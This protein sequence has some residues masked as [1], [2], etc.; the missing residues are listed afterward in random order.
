M[1]VLSKV[2]D[3]VHSFS[4]VGRSNCNNRSISTMNEGAQFRHTVSIQG[5]PVILQ[6]DS[7]KTLSALFPNQV[8]CAT[9]LLHV[10]Y[11]IIHS[12]FTYIFPIEITQQRLNDLNVS[13]AL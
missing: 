11:I 5:F 3:T 9:G 13:I 10:M 6:I 8:M 2:E 12:T 7:N 4:A 1:K